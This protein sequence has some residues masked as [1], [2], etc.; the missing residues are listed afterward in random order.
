MAGKVSRMEATATFTGAVRQA[1][2]AAIA[3]SGATLA[4]VSE[5]T[6]IAQSSL[7]RKLNTPAPFTVT[8]L[9][10]IARH[11]GIPVEQLSAPGR[12][13]A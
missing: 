12:A 6:G 5:G 2:K 11:L 10:L 8:E 1:V 7:S 4:A 3:E 13:V 9:D